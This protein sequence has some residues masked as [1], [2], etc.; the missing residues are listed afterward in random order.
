M[1]RTLPRAMMA[2]ADE[3]SLSGLEAPDIR[4][5]S[6]AFMSRMTIRSISR[7]PSAAKPS[8]SSLQP[9]TSDVARTASAVCARTR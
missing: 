3:L 5:D 1:R 6:S 2:I 7:S 4:T 8:S 9:V